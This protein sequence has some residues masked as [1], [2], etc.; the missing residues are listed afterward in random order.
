MRPGTVDDP[1]LSSS[2]FFDA[3]SNQRYRRLTVSLVSLRN[4]SDYTYYW[5]NFKSMRNAHA[6]I[7]FVSL[8]YR[9]LLFAPKYKTFFGCA[10]GK[11]F[12]VFTSFLS[13]QQLI[14]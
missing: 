7:I 6:H 2:V 5:T 8:R 12:N 14:I 10:T 4:R 13:K 1:K 11:I 3:K 9:R